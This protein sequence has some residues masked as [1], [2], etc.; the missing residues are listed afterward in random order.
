MKVTDEDL[1]TAFKRK[2]PLKYYLI[3][4]AP[5]LAAFLC[6]VP[7]R[8]FVIHVILT[9]LILN[10]LIIAVFLT[11]AVLILIRIHAV[12]KEYE[13]LD[14]FMEA[15]LS[16]GSAADLLEE[17]G[18]KTSRV[19]H[20]LEN[21]V[22]TEGRIPSQMVQTAMMKEIDHVGHAFQSTYEIPNYIVG[23]LIALGLAGTFI[24]LL[25]TML[26]LSEMLGS[27]NSGGGDMS[28]AVLGLIGKLQTP[29]AG[30]GTAF[31]ASLFGL[32][33]S[34][35]LGMMM[36]SLKYAVS[37][38][39]TAMTRY[40]AAV[41]E[42]EDP[43]EGVTGGLAQAFAMP[44][45]RSNTEEFFRDLTAQMADHYSGSQGLFRQSQES[46]IGAVAR[47]DTLTA[48]MGRLAELMESHVDTSK[49]MYELLGYGPRMR[50][51]SEQTLAEMKSMTA[52]QARHDEWMAK[53][54]SSVQA[55]DQRFLGANTQL[56]EMAASFTRLDQ[57][58]V[59]R[60]IAAQMVELMKE[61][62]QGRQVA[63]DIARH[64]YATNDML[65]SMQGDAA[66]FATL[67]ENGA[68][69]VVLAE[70]L[71]NELRGART[72]IARDLRAELRELVRTMPERD[73]ADSH[74]V[75]GEGAR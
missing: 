58:E 34:S 70:M 15:S 18:V 40:I 33:G 35:F 22:E 73:A 37:Q 13:V 19:G 74:N 67:Q 21:V 71:L 36:L 5:V 54:T 6:A 55:L 48:A 27:M 50:E 42:H 14:R 62:A 24:G 47:L 4:I 2:N 3:G 25:E 9:N 46:M 41:V 29:L 60:L 30:M 61:S 20:V 1:G 68:K 23:L 44:N 28:T 59:I 45:G 49:K 64:L 11:G 32:L 69:Q 16:G 51:L 7:F 38:F 8:G 31:S 56:G 72:S 66:V 63:T 75:N 65:K 53:L 39:M 10:G 12:Q 52:G 43:S 17:P 57:G 26:G